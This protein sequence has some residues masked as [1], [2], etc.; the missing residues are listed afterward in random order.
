MWRRCL[1]SLEVYDLEVCDFV[2]LRTAGITWPEPEEFTITRV[3]RDREWFARV[4]PELEAFKA[5][6]ARGVPRPPSPKPKAARKRK[7]TK[8]P[9]VC[10]LVSD[11]EG[12]DEGQD[13]PRDASHVATIAADVGQDV[14]VA[15]VLAVHQDIVQDTQ[16]VEPAGDMQADRSQ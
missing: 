3:H 10:E 11:D 16:R 9:V 14:L 2:Q 4:L 7:A 8:K 13:D 1:F 15:A 12:D 6:L 5:E